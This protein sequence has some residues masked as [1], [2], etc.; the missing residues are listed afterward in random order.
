MDTRRDEDKAS[1]LQV[2]DA[3][4]RAFWAKDIDAMAHLH[5]QA[6]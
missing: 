5:V 6:P 4:N 1:I 2:I 3:K